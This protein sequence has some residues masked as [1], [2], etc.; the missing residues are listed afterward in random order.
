MFGI[1]KEN[2]IEATNLFMITEILNTQFKCLQ[3]IREI[4]EDFDHRLDVL[5]AFQK[6]SEK[7]VDNKIQAKKKK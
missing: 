6:G 4:I 2:K 7:K 3:K 1:K 5:E